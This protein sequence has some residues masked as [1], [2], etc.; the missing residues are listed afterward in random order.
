MRSIWKYATFSAGRGSDTGASIAGTEIASGLSRNFTQHLWDWARLLVIGR[1][2]TSPA[3]RRMMIGWAPG[4]T[5]TPANTAIL[6]GQIT[7]DMLRAAQAQPT[8][9]RAR[10]PQPKR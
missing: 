7:E 3:M 8:G 6:F 9:T 2:L 1:A 10:Q 5:F 4:R